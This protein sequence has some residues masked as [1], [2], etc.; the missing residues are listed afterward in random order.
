M[1]LSPF[2]F[3]GGKK[4]ASQIKANIPKAKICIILRKPD[5]RAYSQ[6]NLLRN[7]VFYSKISYIEFLT[8]CL[9]FQQEEE[10]LVNDK[11]FLILKESD[12]AT[13]IEEWLFVFNISDVHIC[14]YDDLKSN[15]ENFFNALFGF[16]KLE[17]L[18]VNKNDLTIENRT[19]QVNSLLLH[20]FATIVARGFEP[21]LNRYPF[22]KDYAK[23]LYFNLNGKKDIGDTTKLIAYGNKLI[24]E[25]I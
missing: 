11:N 20:K 1:E 13:L 12:Y 18:T 9:K 4:L 23:I 8:K 25:H 24:L 10:L 16:C 14:F 17:K 19:R 15:P 3:L 7:K 2:Y 21:L 22:M 6:F 5:E